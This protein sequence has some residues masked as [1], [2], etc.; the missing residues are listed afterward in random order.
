VSRGWDEDIAGEYDPGPPDPNP[1]ARKPHWIPLV[2]SR[3]EVRELLASPEV[4]ETERVVLRTLYASGIR[5]REFLGLKAEDVRTQTSSLRFGQREALLDPVTCQQLVGFDWSAWSV[6]RVKDVLHRAA[7]GCSVWKRYRAMGRKLRAAALRVAFATHCLENGSGLF[8]LHNLLGYSSLSDTEMVIEVAVGLWRSVYDRAHPLALGQGRL[9]GGD[10]QSDLS[11]EEVL[12][13]LEAAGE[14]PHKTHNSLMLRVI[15]AAG[16]RVGELAKLLVAD[17][18]L[19]E[20]RLFLRDAK[21]HKDRYTLIDVGTAELLRAVVAGRG[22]DEPVFMYNG[23]AILDSFVWEFIHEAGDKTGLL[24]KWTALGRSLSPH[25]F[26]HAHAGHLYAGGMEPGVI[27]KLLGHNSV[28]ETMGYVA[29]GP[30]EWREAYD[31]CRLL[32]GPVTT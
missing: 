24:Q 18:E 14:G 28:D 13:M 2:I 1:K 32:E 15:Y 9:R 12:T 19:D 25:S 8:G 10:K 29:C 7:K 31:R 27:K 23:K 3:R 6:V 4:D 21:E 11:L 22:L 5:D 16:L 17:L 30:V 26:R 20:R